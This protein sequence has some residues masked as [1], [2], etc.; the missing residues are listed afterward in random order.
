M[1]PL[2]KQEEKNLFADV[3]KYNVDFVVSI[4]VAKMFWDELPEG[5]LG[6]F[7]EP[8]KIVLPRWFKVIGTIRPGVDHVEDFQDL[9]PTIGHELVHFKQYTENPVGY[10]FRKNRLIAR[11]TIEPPA[12]EE[13]KRIRELIGRKEHNQEN[14]G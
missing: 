3:R 6:V 12:F 8:D 5:C 14:Y 7:Y 13:E 11:W 10:K 1:E 2:T 9:L 4:G